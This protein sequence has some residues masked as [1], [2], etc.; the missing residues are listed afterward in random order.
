MRIE[1]KRDEFIS[2]LRIPKIE[3][4]LS[5][6]SSIQLHRFAKSLYDPQQRLRRVVYF[7]TGSIYHFDHQKRFHGFSQD[8]LIHQSRSCYS[9]GRRVG[10]EYINTT[11]K[12]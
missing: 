10:I 8:L 1:V 3:I 9:H 5:D 6:G 12:Q 4:S 2:S 11:W 7:N